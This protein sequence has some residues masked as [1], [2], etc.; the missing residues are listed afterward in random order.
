MARR[1]A[2]NEKSRY[3]DPKQMYVYGNTVTKPEY[4]PRRHVEEPEKR[5]RA[6]RQVKKN[7]KNALHMS[8]GYVFFLSVAAVMAL[9]VCVNHVQLQA[10]VT[11]RSKNITMMQEEL[12]SLKEENNTKYNVITDSVS[13]EEVRVKAETELG[14]VYATENQIVEYSNP[15]GDYVK[16]YEEIPESGV[17]ASA[18]KVEK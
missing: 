8:P 10:K 6:S 17:L 14:M 7:R 5:K 15:S 18:D 11:S 2:A 1:A 16:Q 12:A 3:T 4:E 9:V 13:L